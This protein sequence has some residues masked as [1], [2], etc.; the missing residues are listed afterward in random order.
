M[1]ARLT[2]PGLVVPSVASRGIP[3]CSVEEH[4]EGGDGIAEDDRVD[5]SAFADVAPGGPINDRGDVV[6]GTDPHQV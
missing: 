3:V 2:L 1:S 6:E 4:S 5:K